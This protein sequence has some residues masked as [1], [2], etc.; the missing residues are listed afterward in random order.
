[1]NRAQDD[2]A[3]IEKRLAAAAEDISHGVEF[4]YIIVNDDFDEALLDLTALVRS[5]RLT[6]PRQIE[7]HRELFTQFSESVRGPA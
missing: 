2:Q 7:R 4:D 1:M 5:A 3:V 6:T